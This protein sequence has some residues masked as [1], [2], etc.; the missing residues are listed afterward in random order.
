MKLF[1]FYSQTD[2]FCNGLIL[3]IHTFYIFFTRLPALL[4]LPWCANTKL[5]GLRQWECNYEIDYVLLGF[6]LDSIAL[7]EESG[8]SKIMKPQSVTFFWVRV[9]RREFDI[10]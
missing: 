9:F 8:A 2:L 1:L 5:L 7:I 6:S 10:L 3:Y 4:A